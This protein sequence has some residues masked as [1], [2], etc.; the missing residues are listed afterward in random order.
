MLES[1][2]SLSLLSNKKNGWKMTKIK[3]DIKIKI[4]KII[5]TGTQYFEK[6]EDENE[7]SQ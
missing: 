4:L 7:L 5:E 3:F 1:C 2:D 6:I